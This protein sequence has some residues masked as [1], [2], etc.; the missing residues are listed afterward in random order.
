M[1]FSRFKAVDF[2]LSNPTTRKYSLN[3]KVISGSDLFTLQMP[4]KPYSTSRLPSRAM[5]SSSS[6]G[7]QSTSPTMCVPFDLPAQSEA[8]LVVTFTPAEYNSEESE[9]R[10]AFNCLEVIHSFDMKKDN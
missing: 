2:T 6:S 3:S 10:A 1:A 9:G 5:I 8:K 7:N 4:K